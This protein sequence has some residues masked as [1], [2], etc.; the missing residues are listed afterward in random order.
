MT[1]LAIVDDAFESTVASVDD[2]FSIRVKPP[3]HSLGFKWKRDKLKT[4]I[5]RQAEPTTSGIETSLLKALRYHT[6]LYYL[7]RLGQMA[8]FMQILTAYAIRRGAGEAVD[9]T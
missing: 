9:G 2:I 5:F 1:T 6:Y 7:Q 3:R 8:G 4:P